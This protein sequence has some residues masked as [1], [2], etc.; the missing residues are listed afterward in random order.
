MN[1][2]MSLNFKR[3]K[4]SV[5]FECRR[6]SGALLVALEYDDVLLDEWCEDA[7]ELSCDVLVRPYLQHE[8]KL[9]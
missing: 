5:H 9:K 4:G 8:V 2:E 1:P 7:E 6:R 3:Q